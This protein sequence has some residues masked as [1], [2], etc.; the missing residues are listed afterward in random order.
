[1]RALLIIAIV[2]A[3][4]FAPTA[5]AIAP[6]LAHPY[7]GQARVCVLFDDNRVGCGELESRDLF[8]SEDICRAEMQ[9]RLTDLRAFALA[10][11]AIVDY[12]A[13]Y[14]CI[15]ARDAWNA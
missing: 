3:T 15:P 2:L 13:E 14:R 1:M 9:R 11:R 4:M 6:Q 10:N 5:L 12:R 8:D 7:R